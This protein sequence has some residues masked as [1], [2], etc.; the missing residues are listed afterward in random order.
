MNRPAKAADSN[1][2]RPERLHILAKVLPDFALSN[3]VGHAKK[4]QFQK[5]TVAEID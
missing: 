2:Q 1:T 3:G 4:G 5:W